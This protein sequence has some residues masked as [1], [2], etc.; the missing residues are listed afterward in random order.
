MR[1]DIEKIACAVPGGTQS[2]TISIGIA[3]YPEHGA[4]VEDIISQADK[5]LFI[6]KSHGKNRCTLAGPT[7]ETDFEQDIKN[8]TV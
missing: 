5:A 7:S 3:G 2:I 8:P 4:Q 6:G 1:M